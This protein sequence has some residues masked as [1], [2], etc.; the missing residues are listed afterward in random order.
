M[1]EKRG[2][3]VENKLQSRNIASV[4]FASARRRPIFVLL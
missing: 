1:T 3:G 2:R 4:S